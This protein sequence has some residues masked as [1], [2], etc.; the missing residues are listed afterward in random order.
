MKMV[1]AAVESTNIPIAI[2]LDHGP[3][4]ETCK[5]CIDS[6]FTSVMIDGSRFPLEE[7]IALTKKVVDYAFS[8]LTAKQ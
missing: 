6:G 5:D 1:E 7:N 4:F 3:D 2:H 8:S